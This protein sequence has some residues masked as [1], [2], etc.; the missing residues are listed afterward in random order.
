MLVRS[1]VLVAAVWLGSFADVDARPRFYATRVAGSSGTEST[2]AHLFSDRTWQIEGSVEHAGRFLIRT[3]GSL[4]ESAQPLYARMLLSRE[5]LRV[6]RVTAVYLVPRDKRPIDR[7]QSRLARALRAVCDF[8]E[9]EL[10][11]AVRFELAA[12]PRGVEGMMPERGYQVAE[13]GFWRA[14]V[15]ESH[16]AASVPRPAPGVL[17]VLVVFVEGQQR[18]GGGSAAGRIEG[19]PV[20]LISGEVI[21]YLYPDGMPHPETVTDPL[22]RGEVAWDW[23]LGCTAH[24]LGHA[25]GL[26]HPRPGD[27]SMMSGGWIRGLRNAK[28]NA[29]QK[30]LLFEPAENAGYLTRWRIAGPYAGLEAGGFPV[31]GASREIV[32]VEGPVI[33]LNAA[34]IPRENVHAYARTYVRSGREQEVVLAVG[35]DDA[36]V[37][38]LNGEQ[39]LEHHDHQRL[40]LD[41]DLVTVTFHEGWNEVL[42]LCGNGAGWWEFSVGVR[43]KDDPG[44]LMVSPDLTR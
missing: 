23:G 33:D 5:P 35:S 24:E 44:E 36:I 22:G 3:R 2:L 21:P 31:A 15:S 25:F 42:V 28:L 38:W 7:W 14:V 1:L 40:Q 34:L 43:P 26:P 20:A 39:V 30:Q 13:E 11:R 19:A 17:D 9:A 4:V 41:R 8:W 29:R 27:A 6:C 12:A 18:N 10:E 37:L 32:E 16:R